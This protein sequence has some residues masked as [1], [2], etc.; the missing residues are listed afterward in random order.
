M[1]LEGG[2]GGSGRPPVSSEPMEARTVVFSTSTQ[3]Q[4]PVPLICLV[5]GALRLVKSVHPATSVWQQ[6]FLAVTRC[7]W[8]H[9]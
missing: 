4:G 7:G 9:R 2:R 1:L 5:S 6:T 3:E 8:P